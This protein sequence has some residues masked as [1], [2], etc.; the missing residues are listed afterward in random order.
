MDR[1]LLQLN[2]I[3]AEYII[4]FHGVPE[5][6][7]PSVAY[8][9]AA[10]FAPARQREIKCPYCRRTLTYVDRSTK[11]E[12]YRF[13]KRQTVVCHEYRKCHSCHETVGISFAQ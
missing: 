7:Y 5:D 4:V 3:D 8:R 1:L 9:R 6:M 11:V 12:L 13:P 2:K 10:G